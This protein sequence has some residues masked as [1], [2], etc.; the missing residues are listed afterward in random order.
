MKY[1]LFC[2]AAFLSAQRAV[3][4]HLQSK[5]A[6]FDT[7]TFGKIIKTGNGDIAYHFELKDQ[8]GAVELME[9]ES[10]LPFS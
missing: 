3:I 4:D 2:L 5:H 10:G 9:G 6:Q 7:L 8:E 1:I